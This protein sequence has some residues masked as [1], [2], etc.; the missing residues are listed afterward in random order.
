M[1]IASLLER[2]SCSRRP[3][4]AYSSRSRNRPERQWLGELITRSCSRRT[5]CPPVGCTTQRTYRPG[6]ARVSSMAGCKR[7]A[8]ILLRHVHSAAHQGVAELPAHEEPQGRPA[9]A[10][11]HQNGEHG[12]VSGHRS[13]RRTGNGKAKG[14]VAIG[15]WGDSLSGRS[16]PGQERTPARSRVHRIE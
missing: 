6:S 9:S 3:S 4:D 1:V 15:A 11:S 13:R 7:S 5:F 2:S 10:G 14:S 12:S 8:W 16:L